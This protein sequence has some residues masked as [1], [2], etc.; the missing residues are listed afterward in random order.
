MNSHCRVSSEQRLSELNSNGNADDQYSDALGS[1]VSMS[2]RD[3]AFS[4]GANATANTAMELECLS[5]V[6]L[7][8]VRSRNLAR[9]V[10]QD[11]SIEVARLPPHS[12][13]SIRRLMGSDSFWA[14][15]VAGA[16]PKG[17]V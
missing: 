11:V 14:N 4:V 6:A 16:R 13:W 3:S 2:E 12:K 9:E 7:W 8:D 15:L 5:P 17:A 10:G 1:G